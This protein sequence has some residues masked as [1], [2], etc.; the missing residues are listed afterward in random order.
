MKWLKGAFTRRRRYDELSATIREH[1]EEKIADLTDRGMTRKEAERTTR[2]EF[3]NVTL[4][5]QRSREVWQWPRFESLWADTRFACR[6]LRR[7]PGFTL[8][9]VLIMACGIGASAAVFSAINSI[10]LRPYAFRDPGQIVIWHEVVQE[11]AKQYPFVPDNYRHFLYLKSHATTIHDAA[12]LQNTSFAVTAGGDHPRIVNGL[13]VSP[14]FFSVLGVTPMLGRG[15]L[16]EESQTGRS[17]VVVISWAAWNDLFHADPGAVGHTIK[18]QGRQTT[19]IGVLP[20]GFD[21]PVVHEMT[22]GASPGKILAYEVFHPFVAQGDDLTSDDADFAFLVVARLNNGVSVRQASAELGGMLSAYSVSN[23][24]PIHLGIFVRPLQQEVTGNVRKAFWLLFAAVLGL[25]LIACVNLAS[26][27]LTRAIVRGRDYALRFA[28]GAGRW[29]QFQTALMESIVLCLTGG[30]AGILLAVGGV[31]VLVGIAPANLPRL[32]EIHITGGVLLFACGLSFMAALLSGMFPALRSLAS[33]PQR[34]LQSSSTRVLRGGHTLLARR[35]LVAFEIAC[36][37][38]LLIVTGVV[39]RSFSRVL[40]QQHGFDASR[41]VLSEVD[42]LSPNYQGDSGDAARAAFIESLLDKIRSTPG[43]DYAAITSAMPLSGE[44]AVHSIYRPDHPLPESKVPT[45]NLRNISPGYFT[46]MQTPLL[47]GH[48]FTDSERSN[49]RSAIL[50]QSAARAAWPEGQ[51]LGRQFRFD[52]RI[53]TV[54]GIAVDARIA[55]LKE[56]IPVVYL[57]FWHEPPVSVFLLVRTS[58]A[59]DEFAPVLRRD[60]W[61]VG[62]DTA[63]PTVETLDRQIAASVAPERLQSIVLS[64]FGVTALTLAILGIYGVLAYSVSLRTP[65]FGIRIALGSSKAEL[66][67]IVLLEVLMPVG[68]GSTFGLIAAVMATR[69]I[70]SMLYETSSADPMSIAGTLVLL[71]A[72]SFAAAFLPAYRASR[73]DLMKVLRQE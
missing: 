32:G 69:A 51:A 44:A 6:Q 67:R 53:Y 28:L 3:G 37:V 18:F 50:S 73:V 1:L 9:A 16:P 58:R 41:V 33:D 8:V 54:T 63:I 42:L 14:Q 71:L 39:V 5:E 68:S 24:L 45:A 70:R 56:D 34:A 62:P 36:T 20:Q 59:L 40:N 49:P 26:L 25:L 29:R 4:I 72:A 57:P 10:L 27:Q 2:R 48:E 60:V 15:F 65:E 47:A 55:N 23:H 38:V 46:V 13:N 12:L 30:V 11:A 22:G 17:D 61:E 21:F 66:I 35:I 31:R 43:V 52:G 64:S 7:T 19:V